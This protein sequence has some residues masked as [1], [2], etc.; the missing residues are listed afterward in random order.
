MS[1][2]LLPSFDIRDDRLRSD[3]YTY[4]ASYREIEPVHWSEKA[5]GW[6]LTRYDHI[7]TVLQ[8]SKVDPGSVSPF[9]K[10]VS[11]RGG[12]N[13]R[14]LQSFID[15][16]LFFDSTPGHRNARR[17]LVAT[18][19]ERPLSSYAG[20]IAE[21]SRDLLRPLADRRE[22]DAVASY[23]DP[24]PFRVMCH[25]M[26]IPRHIEENLFS[27][28]RGML[29]LF[30][31]IIGERDMQHY[32]GVFSIAFQEIAA[33]VEERRQSPRNDGIS[34]II[35]FSQREGEDDL[36]WIYSRVLFLILVGSETTSAFLATCI[37]NSL[38]NRK[39]RETILNH[40]D[41]SLVINEFLRFDSPVT[42]AVRR[43]KSDIILGDQTIPNNSV[44]YPYFIAGNRDPA[45]YFEPDEFRPEREGPPNLAFG[46]GS[47]AC[48]GGALARLEA[49]IAVPNFLASIAG[50]RVIEGPTE[51]LRLDS[52]R[53][54]ARLPIATD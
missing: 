36:H 47:H 35:A 22:F 44:V 27:I 50:A 10:S 18:L 45:C 15:A 23:T 24:L 16:V 30:N 20:V 3:P 29:R 49:R 37:L 26:G 9:I 2:E 31:L 25:I 8:S 4:L 39:I 32:N 51:W 13:W 5:Q 38:N 28:S 52:F 42:L 19:N 34:R 21:I 17:L 40:H 7:S 53:R 12:H 46:V 1:A 11:E 48:I 54:L 33:L 43:T 6:I 14:E 41:K